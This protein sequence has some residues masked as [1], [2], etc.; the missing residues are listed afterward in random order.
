MTA[1][2]WD[3]EILTSSE[4]NNNNLCHDSYL[5]IVYENECH[6]PSKEHHGNE[7]TLREQSLS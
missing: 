6:T 5:S 1:S 7:V 3:S 2:F 4:F